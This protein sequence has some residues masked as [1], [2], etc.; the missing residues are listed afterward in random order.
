LQ[1]EKAVEDLMKRI[2]EIYEALYKGEPSA[3]GYYWYAYKYTERGAMMQP[4]SFIGYDPKFA[5]TADHLLDTGKT[6]ADFSGVG[7]VAYEGPLNADQ[8][9]QYGLLGV[10]HDVDDA[11]IYLDDP[12]DSLGEIGEPGEPVEGP[13]PEGEKDVPGEREEPEGEG[14]PAD[15]TTPLSDVAIDYSITSTDNLSNRTEAERFTAN[16]AALRVLL[17]IEGE[18]R[19]ATA[20][21]QKILVQYS[22]WGGISGALSRFTDTALNKSRK[23]IIAELGL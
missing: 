9:I 20:D 14:T 21:E 19:R 17:K 2:D 15:A 13:R 16:V 6:M 5:L 23:Q 8:V 11:K 10:I 3:D 1:A 4:K 12:D 18:N 22:S 7:A